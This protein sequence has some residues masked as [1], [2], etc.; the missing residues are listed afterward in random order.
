MFFFNL[1]KNIRC[2]GK[3]RKSFGA[4][5]K[6]HLCYSKRVHKSFYASGFLYHS[7]SQ[8]ILLQQLNGDNEAN[9]VLF[10]E[11]SHTGEDPQTVFQH[12]VE[13]ALG[14]T[15]KA[16]SLHPVYDYVHT[17]LGEHFIF[18]V[19]MADINPINYSSGNSTGWLPLS[20]LSK[21]SMTEQTRHDIIIGE[22][23][24]RSLSSL[25]T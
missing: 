18:Y 5:E 2:H 14:I 24:I 11:K 19:E 17:R 23:V 13:K 16:T 4:A 8:Q 15:L 21:Y 12:C 1:G 7:P 22:R 6:F 20:K 10:C 3:Q 9:L 25:Q